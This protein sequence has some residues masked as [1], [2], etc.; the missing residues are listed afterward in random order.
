MQNENKRTAK[1]DHSAGN[2]AE[3]GCAD[4]SAFAGNGQMGIE[5]SQGNEELGQDEENQLIDFLYR[6]MSRINSLVS[7]LFKGAL[8]SVAIS[9]SIANHDGNKLRVGIPLLHG[10]N[11]ASRTETDGMQKNFDPHDINL[12]DLLATLEPIIN[13]RPLSMTDTGR[14]CIL[15]GQLIVR[16]Y[17]TLKQTAPVLFESKEVQ[18]GISPANKKQ[19]REIAK[20]LA[21]ILKIVPMGIELEL[22]TLG[23]E[24][25][26]G[27]AKADCFVDNIDDVSRTFGTALPGEWSILGIA[28]AIGEKGKPRSLNPMRQSMDDLAGATRLMYSGTDSQ[29]AIT[30]ILIFRR[31]KIT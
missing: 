21:S 15:T 4:E 5:L 8:T 19:G 23:G 31:L 24:S 20:M 13:S 14:L 1:T 17:R 11:M 29:H 3:T 7:Q 10:D 22:N 2:I 30:P 9:S 18:D 25:V 16:D 12:I 28:D 27:A 26:I 6:D